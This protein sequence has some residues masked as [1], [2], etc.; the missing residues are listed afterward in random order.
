MWCLPSSSQHHGM[1]RCDVLPFQKING[2]VS[3]F[4]QDALFIGGLCLGWRPLGQADYPCLPPVGRTHFR[5]SNRLEACNSLWMFVAQMHSRPIL[6]VILLSGISCRWII[7]WRRCVNK[8]HS[9]LP[10]RSQ[11]TT[12]RF[13]STSKLDTRVLQLRSTIRLSNRHTISSNPIA[14]HHTFLPLP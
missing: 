13:F 4:P 1:L 5:I 3:R 2:L 11:A 6:R 8:Y 12:T 9:Q 10:S 7:F 14:R